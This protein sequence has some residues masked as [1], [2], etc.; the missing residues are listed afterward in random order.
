LAEGD[1]QG[2]SHGKLHFALN[3]AINGNNAQ[4]ADSKMTILKT[5]NVGIGNPSPTES[6]HIG[7]GQANTIRIHNAASGDVTSGLNITRGDSLGMQLYDNPAD[8]TTTL[9]ASGNFNIRT[10]NTSYRLFVKDN[11]SVAVGGNATAGKSFEVQGKQSG[12]SGFWY[13]DSNQAHGRG[14]SLTHGLM[15][16]NSINYDGDGAYWPVAGFAAANDNAASESVDFWF[17]STTNEWQPMTFFA[18]GAHTGSGQ[19]GQTAG[20]ALIRATHYNNSL[21]VSILD[22]GGGGTFTASIIGSYGANRADTSRVRITYSS[23]QNR[24]VVSVW[25]VN[26]SGFYGAQRS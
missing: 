4:I 16:V 8:D 26:Y 18:V 7:T 22:S 24:T 9:N 23:N 3:S 25:G 1:N 13:D 14:V 10:D 21:S 5:G 6:L 17:G 12:Y 2:Y 15:G 11:G 19:T 20:W